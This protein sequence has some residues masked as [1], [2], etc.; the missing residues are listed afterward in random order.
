MTLYGPTVHVIKQITKKQNEKIIH[1]SRAW[2]Y[3]FRA[4]IDTGIMTTAQ[5]GRPRNHCSI[6]FTVGQQIYLFSKT[7][8]RV[9]RPTQP[10]IHTC[11]FYLEGKAT[12]S[13]SDLSS[14]SRA[15]V[16]DG[17]RFS[18][19]SPYVLTRCTGIP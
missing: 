3:V 5:A 2:R 1:F 9:L 10:S 8:Y 7:S 17:W 6:R 18:F 14:T 4:A 11:S 12:A 13:I 16:E 15:D 19:M